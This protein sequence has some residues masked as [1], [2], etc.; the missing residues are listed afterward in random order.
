MTSILGRIF[1][2]RTGGPVVPSRGDI[3]YA[4]AMR[5]S[6]D[7]L[8]RMRESSGSSDAARAIMSDVWAQS[9]NIPFLTTVYES[10]QEA[11]SGPESNRK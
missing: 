11:K 10:V 8:R 5:E 6:D 3:A 2:D 4:D 9:H 7:L 1:P